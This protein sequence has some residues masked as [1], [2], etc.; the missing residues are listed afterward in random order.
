MLI[1][2]EYNLFPFHLGFIILFNI[3]CIEVARC[4]ERGISGAGMV[5]SH[6]KG[7][8]CC[9][10][11]HATFKTTGNSEISKFRLHYVQDNCKLG[12][13]NKLQ[14]GKIVLNGHPTRNS[15]S[16]L[17]DLKITDI[18]T[19]YFSEFQVIL[20]APTYLILS[21]SVDDVDTFDRSNESTQTIVPNRVSC[22]STVKVS[23]YCATLI[24]LMKFDIFQSDLMNQCKRH[25][26]YISSLC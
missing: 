3:I 13:K 5:L 18:T 21:Q 26:P 16:G 20:N 9:T 17:S 25:Q 12:E 15:N 1:S 14:L 2:S 22:S 11:R 4:F 19:S 8:I 10:D 7:G 24:S 6:Y 23:A